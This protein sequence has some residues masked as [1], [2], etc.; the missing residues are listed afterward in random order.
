MPD[1]VMLADNRADDTRPLIMRPTDAG[2]N[3]RGHLAADSQLTGDGLGAATEGA[4]TAVQIPQ[5]AIT[6][7]GRRLTFNAYLY[8]DADNG[9]DTWTVRVRLGGL[10]GVLIVSSGA[11]DLAAA[12]GVWVEGML[13]IR[14][15]GAGGTFDARVRLYN[16]VGPTVVEDLVFAGAVDT[17]VAQDLVVTGESSSANANQQMTLRML[18]VLGLE[19]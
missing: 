8:A 15:V 11:F 1:R 16:E 9:A 17:T 18:D 12:A 10:A 6:A 2:T 7:A 19:D 13:T 3:W 4:H 5:P 14:T